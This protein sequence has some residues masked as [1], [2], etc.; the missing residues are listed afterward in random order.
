[1]NYAHLVEFF[2]GLV[3]GGELGGLRTLFTIRIR[4]ETRNLRKWHRGEHH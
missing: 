2:S 3:S 1:M 4:F